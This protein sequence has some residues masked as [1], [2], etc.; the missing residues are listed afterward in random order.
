MLIAG[1]R[2]GHHDRGRDPGR[3]RLAAEH[4]PATEAGHGHA[5][6]R[7][8]RQR[9]LGAALDQVQA[10][11]R[12]P[13]APIRNR[14]ASEPPLRSTYVFLGGCC[15]VRATRPPCGSQKLSWNAITSPVT[16]SRIRAASACSPRGRPGMSASRYR[17]SILVG[18]DRLGRDAALLEVE[19]GR[20][21]GRDRHEPV[22]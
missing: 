14:P 11:R 7:R 2:S 16:A 6:G 5:A 22:E 4:L 15:L 8:D 1:R 20:A 19:P 10:G 13:A 9:L 17:S 21:T 12:A 18:R 3:Q